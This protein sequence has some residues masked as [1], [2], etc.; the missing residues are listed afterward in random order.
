MDYRKIENEVI[1]TT[2]LISTVVNDEKFLSLTSDENRFNYIKDMA[3]T[4]FGIKS[5]YTFRQFQVIKAEIVLWESVGASQIARLSADPMSSFSTGEREF[6]DFATNSTNSA[7]DI[8]SFN[9]KI[10]ALR[11]GLLTSNF[12][13]WLNY[14]TDRISMLSSWLAYY[15][16]YV[17][18][19]ASDD[20][21]TFNPYNIPGIFPEPRVSAD[22]NARTT[23]S[24]KGFFKKMCIAK[25]TALFAIGSSVINPGTGT[26]IG[27]A[28]GFLV[29]RCCKCCT[30][31]IVVCDL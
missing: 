7:S 5:E 22:A 15:K 29:G 8:T 9:N 6:I 25:W 14:S 3:A 13:P 24:C 31:N 30:C 10:T 4:S 1:L 28:A 20:F 27:A 18:Q 17:N 16:D 19:W 23:G 2:K 21:D 12:Y 26:L 11:N